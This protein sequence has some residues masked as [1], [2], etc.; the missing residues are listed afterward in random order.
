MCHQSYERVRGIDREARN[1]ICFSASGRNR[2]WVVG[3]VS[4]EVI[5]N[6]ANTGL[7]FCINLKR[8]YFAF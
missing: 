3:R 8:Q 2:S 5:S 7:S 6:G 4:K 1:D